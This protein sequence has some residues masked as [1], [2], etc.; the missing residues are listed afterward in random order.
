VTSF[1]RR[2]ERLEEGVGGCEECEEARERVLIAVT[3]KLEGYRGGDEGEPSE[4]PL[5]CLACGRD[6]K[7]PIELID[8]VLARKRA[9]EEEGEGGG[10]REL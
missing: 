3:E 5:A 10:S 4:R 8:E 7:I 1:E 9:F 2:L 6:A